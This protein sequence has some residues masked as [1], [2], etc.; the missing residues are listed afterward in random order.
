[1]PILDLAMPGFS[2]N[3]VFDELKQHGLIHQNSV[4]LFTALSKSEDHAKNISGWTKDGHIKT[5]IKG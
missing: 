5:C 4:L 3:G 1:M 2:G